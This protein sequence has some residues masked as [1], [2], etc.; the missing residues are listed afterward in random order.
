MADMNSWQGGDGRGA[1]AAAEQSGKSK[2][3]SS[4][5]QC[6]A[7]NYGLMND[8]LNSSAARAVLESHKRDENG[9]HNYNDGRRRP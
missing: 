5:Q 7:S 2:K 1:A 3:Y 8:A 4:K 6:E 9:N